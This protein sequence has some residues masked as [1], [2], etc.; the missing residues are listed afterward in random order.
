MEGM[1]DQA[2]RLFVFGVP[3]GCY[4]GG[5]SVSIGISKED[6]IARLIGKVQ[7][8]N[9]MNRLHDRHHKALQAAYDR[10][11]GQKNYNTWGSD[12]GWAVKA[13]G[14]DVPFKEEEIKFPWQRVWNALLPFPENDDE[15]TVY[16]AL[17]AALPDQMPFCDFGTAQEDI[18]SF[19]E[20]LGSCTEDNGRLMITSPLAEL[21]EFAVIQGGGD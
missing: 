7:R 14:A 1:R 10:A 2:L 4:T 15:R 17:K 11:F 20:A 18:A 16:H 3:G 12:G 8:S 21:E 13:E 5:I 19:K 6:A 9:E